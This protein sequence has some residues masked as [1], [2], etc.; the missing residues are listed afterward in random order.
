M[1]EYTYSMETMENDLYRQLPPKMILEH[2]LSFLL[3]DIRNDGCSKEVIYDAAGAVWMLSQ[4]RF[5]QYAPVD[6]RDVL[7]F[8]TSP[9]LNRQNCFLYDVDVFRGTELIIQLQV[10]LI[11]VAKEA[12]RIIRPDVLAPLWTAP[13]R[14]TAPFVMSRLRPS[15][16]FTPCGSDEVRYSD[17]DCNGHMTSGAYLS[18]ACN[19][20]EYWCNDP[21]RFM[22][23]MQVDYSSEVYPGTLLRFERGEQ[24]GI[25]YVRGIKPDG[26]VAFTAACEF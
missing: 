15:C 20:L 11:A 24:D 5:S 4:M 6:P 16:E 25:T 12:R 21:S 26:K 13:A 22:R 3:I 8:R 23:T 1:A 10:G 7:T 9:R 17:C 14:E 18:F 19:A 2:G